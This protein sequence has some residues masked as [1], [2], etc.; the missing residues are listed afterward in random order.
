MGTP[1]IRSQAYVTR[2]L[3][4]HDFA[5]IWSFDQMRRRLK[6][7]TR[8]GLNTLVLHE[9]G[10][11]DKI[12]FPAIYLGGKSRGQNFFELAQQL[13][14]QIL[15][16]SI[17][18]FQNAFRHKY[19]TRLVAEA[20]DLGIAVY[21]EDKELWFKDF[22]LKEHPDAFQHGFFCPSR[23]FWWE[24]F[25]PAKY[26]ELFI[27]LPQLAGVVTSFGTGETR[28]SLGNLEHCGCAFCR[29]LDPS[30]WHRNMAVGMHQPFMAA[31]KKM[32]L[33]DFIFQRKEHEQFERALQKLP[34]DIVIAMKNTPHDFYPTFPDNPL[35]GKVGAR[36]QWIEYDVHGQYFGWGMA[37]SIMIDD[38]THRL[39]HG[40]IQGVSG[41]I[42]RTDW[43]G[44]QDHSCFDTPNL[45]NLYAAAALGQDSKVTKRAIYTRWLTDERLLPEETPPDKIERCVDWAMELFECTW[46]IMRS[47][48]FV[49]GTVFSDSGTFHVYLKQSTWIAET[50]HSLKDWQ[51][52]ADSALRM[53]DENAQKIL[54]EKSSALRE[55]T[56]LHVRAAEQNPGL[57]LEAYTTLL[58]HFEFLCW[59]A[60]GFEATTRV[61]VFAR[62]VEHAGDVPVTFRGRPAIEQLREAIRALHEYRDR[63]LRSKFQKSYPAN[64]LL[65]P[66]RLSCFLVDAAKRL[67]GSAEAP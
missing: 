55:A 67:P 8:T 22:V 14:E 51:A 49:N 31:G 65:D 58:S 27:A 1:P 5:R 46:P 24:E 39:E 4:V 43:E 26:T 60:E 56:R 7:M 6:F 34:S 50:L 28:L 33:R 45:L 29:A 15:K 59:Y 37:P 36:E 66:D 9:P 62:M 18:E 35:I 40:R 11:V 63:A 23:P 30:E 3:E 17:R 16:Y 54:E 13:D 64:A 12:V 47:T 44:T 57:T 41:F 42:M 25:L 19:L 53:L 38:L 20:A 52:D 21:L 10:I 48:V 32:V 61:Y 2:A